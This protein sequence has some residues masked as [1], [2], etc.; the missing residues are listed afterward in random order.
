MKDR[1]A[2]LDYYLACDLVSPNAPEFR[3]A[4]AAFDTVDGEDG[5][6]VAEC[7]LI[8]G[9]ISQGRSREEALANVLEAVA[10]A[11]E[12][13]AADGWSLPEGYEVATVTVAA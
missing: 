2:S 5:F 10:L 3:K 4:S 11:L 8:P 7:P 13:R 9:C 1:T 12:C 6:I